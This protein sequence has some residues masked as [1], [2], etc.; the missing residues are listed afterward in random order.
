MHEGEDHLDVARQVTSAIDQLRGVEE[1]VG[2]EVIAFAASITYT[3]EPI[4]LDE[5]LIRNRPSA[6]L[7]NLGASAI[8]LAEWLTEFGH[9]LQA[10]WDQW[11]SFEQKKDDSEE[12]ND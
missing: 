6:E 7:T 4:E 2:A 10:R 11:E 5:E 8:E 12:D 1:F 9:A 3:S